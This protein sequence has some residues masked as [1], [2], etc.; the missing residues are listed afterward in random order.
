MY[1]S[2][3]KYLS[4]L[5]SG[6][7]RFKIWCRSKGLCTIRLMRLTQ[8]SELKK[9]LLLCT[10]HPL[11]WISLL[12]N[13][14]CKFSYL[15]LWLELQFFVQNVICFLL[16]LNR[17]SRPVQKSGK[18]W[19]VRIPDFR[20]F[21]FPDSGPFNIEKNPKIFFSKFSNFFFSN[22]FFQFFFFFFKIF[23]FNFFFHNFFLY[24][25]VVKCLK[26]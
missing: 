21:S 5:W 10:L 8:V 13:L 2:N 17:T 6:S 23:F 9:F 19:N 14:H 1:H 7:N 25:Y 16:G 26:M 12:L 20:F 4:P 22:F 3:K 15:T 18:F 11:N 24:F